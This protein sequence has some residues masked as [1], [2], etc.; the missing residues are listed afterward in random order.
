MDR[1][2]LLSA[3]APA[4]VLASAAEALAQGTPAAGHD[5]TA[6]DSKYR[7]IVDSA[8]HCSMTGQE[9]LAHCL[10][11][12]AAGDTSL[13]A[14]ARSVRELVAICDALQSLAISN[15]IYVPALSKV[16]LTVCTDCEKECRKHASAHAECKAC[17]DACVACANECRKISA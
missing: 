12:F 5:H 9:C 16:A 6:K 15:S 11:S 4:I 13:A 17:A 14:C 2:H 8:S 7:A 1:R 3:L 10:E